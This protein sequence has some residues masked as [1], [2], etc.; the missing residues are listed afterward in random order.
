MIETCTKYKEPQSE[1][2]ALIKPL[3]KEAMQNEF[4]ALV[5]NQTW[6]PVPHQ[7]QK[8]IIDSKRVFKIRYKANVIIERS[9][10]RLVTKGFQQTPEVRL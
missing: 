6:K 7:G 5:T 3:C 4:Q 2:D 10:V 9:K 1:K 8:N